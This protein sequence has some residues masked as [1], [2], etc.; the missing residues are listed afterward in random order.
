[1]TLVAGRHLERRLNRIIQQTHRVVALEAWAE[2]VE[3]TARLLDARLGD[4]DGSEA[5]RQR[6]VFLD[7]LL[8]PRRAWWRQ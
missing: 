2:V 8:V 7:V 3:N 1:M 6:F 4:V 5:A